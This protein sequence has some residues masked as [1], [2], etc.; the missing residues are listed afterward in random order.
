MLC[1][2]FDAFKSNDCL[3]YFQNFLNSCHD[4]MSFSMRTEKEK[5]FF[6]NIEII[7]KQ[8]KFITTV[9][10]KPTFSNVYSNF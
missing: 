2:Y 10:R 6:C 9:Y 8:C 4:N 1:Q 7:H 3:K 5:L